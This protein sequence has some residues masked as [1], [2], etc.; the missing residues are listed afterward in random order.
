MELKKEI[1]PL[2]STVMIELYEENPYEIHE[3]ET[4]L[5]LTS[6]TFDNPD[7]GNK[8]MKDRFMVTGSVKAVG[9]DCKYAHEGDDVM[10][11]VRGLR[12]IIFMGNYYFQV[13]EQNIIALLADDL[14][15][16]FKK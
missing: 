16:R 14:T 3:T 1:M 4:G 11:D 6:G 5:K 12:P 10:V 8:D 7:T 2:Y 9:P 13:A 15:E